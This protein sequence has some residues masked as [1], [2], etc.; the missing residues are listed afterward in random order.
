MEVN[1]AVPNRKVSHARKN[2]RRANYKATVPTLV[3]C[4]HCHE[5]TVAHQVCKNCGYYDGEEVIVK[6]KK[7]NK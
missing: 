7:E 6:D 2:K 5:K 4:P 1:R 3:E